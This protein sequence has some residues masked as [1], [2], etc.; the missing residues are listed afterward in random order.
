MTRFSWNQ[1]IQRAEH[2]AKNYEF[3]AESLRF[4]REIACFQN[5]I[6]DTLHDSFAASVLLPQFPHLLALVQRIGPAPLAQAAS[7][8][9]QENQARWEHLLT[10]CWKSD[11]LPA[12]GISDTD[13][14][15]ARAL[16]QPCAEYVAA[17]TDFSPAAHEASN[18]PFCNRKP[19]VGALRAEG[20][21]AK[22]SL[23][24]SLCSTEW[25]FPRIRC[26]ACGEDRFDWL[27]VYTADQFEHVRVEACDTCKT[28][29]KTVDLTKDGLA[30]P[31]VDELATTPL[32]L[33]AREKGYKKLEPNL[34][35]L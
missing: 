33:W 6:Y 34:L 27:P 22:R 3:A 16:L 21:G 24:C 25:D 31:V 14:F 1:R 30:I 9:A 19:Q 32:D 11:G 8:L 13:V 2:L 4:Y 7:A 23:I 26:P 5:N 10:C 20:Y 29:I 17:H 28:Y 18:C 15:F 12:G 35:R